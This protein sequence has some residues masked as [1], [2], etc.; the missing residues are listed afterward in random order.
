MFLLSA[1]WVPPY[2]TQLP[3]VDVMYGS[4]QCVISYFILHP[5]SDDIP[6]RDKKTHSPTQEE[7]GESHEDGGGPRAKTRLSKILSNVPK[8]SAESNEQDTTPEFAANEVLGT[9]KFDAGVLRRVESSRRGIIGSEGE[10]APRR[11]GAKD[12]LGKVGEPLKKRDYELEKQREVDDL[13]RFREEMMRS[14]DE[15]R[16][17][18]RKEFENEAR[19]KLIVPDYATYK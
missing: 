16:E 15:Q 7:E 14:V 10:G 1:F 11:E 8:N 19:K 9:V 2:P 18:A 6:Q 5:S 17:D 3:T 4:P 13:R 12:Q